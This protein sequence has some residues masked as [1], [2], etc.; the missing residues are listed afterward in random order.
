MPDV[1]EQHAKP[2]DRRERRVYVWW[3]V[4]LGALVLLA[5]FCQFGLRPYLEVRGA[6]RQCIDHWTEEVAKGQVR[7]LGGSE[8]ASKKLAFYARLPKQVAPNKEYAVKLMTYCGRVATQQLIFFMREGDNECVRGEAAHALGELGDPMA[9]EPLIAALEDTESGGRSEAVGALAQLGDPRAVEPLI[10][11]L[12]DGTPDVRYGAAEA[13]GRIKD[14]RAVE[15]LIGGLRDT[16]RRMRYRAAESL[17]RIQDQRAVE[18]LIAALNDN[19]HDVRDNVVRALGW[20][21]DRRGVEPLTATLRDPDRDVRLHA[22]LALQSVNGAIEPLIALLSD[23]DKEIR[24]NAA[25]AMSYMKDPQTIEPMIAA[26][27]D[28]DLCRVAV[29]TLGEIGPTA[30]A[31]IPALETMLKDEDAYVRSAAAEALKKIRG[32]EPPK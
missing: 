23:P 21:R 4:G 10:T 28:K 30:K 3:G 27:S 6:I 11:A 5:L 26:L 16:D 25:F 29:R 22:A 15:P 17:G 9:V 14:P 7:A 13:L 31:A 20:L 8:T 1:T 24:W 2:A 32:E 19:D 18:P 12:H